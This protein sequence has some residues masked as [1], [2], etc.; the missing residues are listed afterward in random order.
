MFRRRCPVFCPNC[1]FPY[2]PDDRFCGRC[3][4]PLPTRETP[5]QPQAAAPKQP[6]AP[7]RPK[8][9]LLPLVL[10]AVLLLAAAAGALAFFLTRP[11][12]LDQSFVLDSEASF[13][14]LVR[15]NGT[16]VEL[17]RGEE[18]VAAL[19]AGSA[20]FRSADISGDKSVLLAAD[21]GGTLYRADAQGCTTLAEQ[22]QSC[23]LSFDG[24]TAVWADGEHHL[25]FQREDGQPETAA[26]DAS[27]SA[28]LSYSGKSLVWETALVPQ[29]GPRYYYLSLDG[30]QSQGLPA[31]DISPILVTDS[32]TVYYVSMHGG[33][34]H[35]YAWKNGESAQLT[36]CLSLSA[37]LLSN[38]D[39][40]QLLY[41]TE[42]DSGASTW[43]YREGEA[44]IQIGAF[45][46]QSICAP[47]YTTPRSIHT[48]ATTVMIF[49][50]NVP[51]LL[52]KALNT[53]RGLWLLDREAAASPVFPEGTAISAA[54]AALDGDSL[55]VQTTG[56]SE[57]NTLYRFDG[58]WGTPT[59]QVLAQGHRLSLLSASPDLS[60]LLYI[61]PEGTSGSRDYYAL[62][63]GGE[64]VLLTQGNEFAVVTMDNT[65][66]CSADDNG[67]TRFLLSDGEGAPIPLE[68]PILED[69]GVYLDVA[70]MGRQTGLA[71]YHEDTGLADLYTVSPDGALTLLTENVITLYP[72]SS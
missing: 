56:P 54:Y 34:L 53:D 39:C 14:F 55:V 32:G 36:D 27:Y 45:T 71:L 4:A 33:S 19:Q 67:I 50:Y 40:T 24:S 38:R 44:P 63:A 25:F 42:D 3:G 30:G 18:Q 70:L 59:S 1:G 6:A 43:F 8:R 66:L 47:T 16:Q 12:P 48:T 65:I 35:L 37:G 68:L 58:L 5:P 52:E 7:A 69:G 17:W 41:V 62:R 31:D 61:L 26:E 2:G 28:F 20:A 64:P 22:A 46:A 11:A 51:T 29:S 15:G 9:R 10:S 60:L 21:A 57:K 72:L 13:F 49:Q 23:T